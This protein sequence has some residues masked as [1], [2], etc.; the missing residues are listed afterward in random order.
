MKDYALIIMKPDALESEL[1]ESIIERYINGGFKIEMVG[2]KSVTPDLI[3]NHYAEVI[4]KLGD[5]FREIVIKDFVGNGMIPVIIS[6]DG[7]NAIA[8]ARELTGATDP[9]QAAPGT[10]RGDLGNDSMEAANRQKRSCYNLVHC[11]DS[12]DSF[13]VELKLWFDPKIVKNFF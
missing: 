10:I 5:G 13:K 4:A 9:S 1:V 7:K 8:N 3:L 11:S 12:T 6:Q 2:Y